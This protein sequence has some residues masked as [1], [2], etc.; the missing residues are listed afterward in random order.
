M[1]TPGNIELN[2][3]TATT[4]AT[5]LKERALAVETLAADF[6]KA[7]EAFEANARLDGDVM[8]ASKATLSLLT[9]QAAK[10]RALISEITNNIDHAGNALNGRV[11]ESRST[12]NESTSVIDGIAALGAGG[13]GTPR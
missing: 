12:E 9:E 3:D 2:Y 1:T 4:A 5:E 7:V 6:Q 10:V 11:A 8:P 13:E